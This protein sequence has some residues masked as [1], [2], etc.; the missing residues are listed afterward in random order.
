MLKNRKL[1]KSISD[2]HE[3]SINN[4]FVHLSTVLLV[5]T[6]NIAA[7]RIHVFGV[8]SLPSAFGASDTMTLVKLEKQICIDGRLST[9]DEWR[10]CTRRAP[11][12]HD[13]NTLYLYGKSS[14]IVLAPAA[15]RRCYRS[16]PEVSA[17]PSQME[18]DECVAWAILVTVISCALWM[19][20]YTTS[21]SS[22]R[23]ALV[24]SEVDVSIPCCWYLLPHPYTCAR[25]LRYSV[26]GARCAHSILCALDFVWI[27]FYLF[28]VD[29]RMFSSKTVTSEWTLKY[30]ANKTPTT[31]GRQ[32]WW[33]AV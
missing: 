3:L 1:H 25:D 11:T 31:I 33:I 18:R 15:R 19:T 21:R 30:G 4:F 10:V 26:S 5:H 32:H 29:V 22:M 16:S 12:A 2:E 7:A 9:S 14:V 8:R 13:R 27:F 6:R 20:N 24:W 28:A 17:C 23:V